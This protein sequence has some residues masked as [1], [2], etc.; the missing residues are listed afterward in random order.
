MEKT[1][2]E[3]YTNQPKKIASEDTPQSIKEQ[4]TE[5][6]DEELDSFDQIS[7]AEDSEEERI[8][9]AKDTALKNE[10]INKGAA[11]NDHKHNEFQDHL[12]SVMSKK[13]GAAIIN[14]HL[15]GLDEISKQETDHAV[16]EK[17]IK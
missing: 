12:H 3:I 11:Q 15:S 8:T 4:T 1:K 9:K 2:T 13:F 6:A 7:Y 10:L 16:N 5:K 17:M 14:K